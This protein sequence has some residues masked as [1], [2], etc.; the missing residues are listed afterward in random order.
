[1]RVFCSQTKF[2][3]PNQADLMVEVQPDWNNNAAGRRLAAETYAELLAARGEGA[4]RSAVWC[5]ASGDS[6]ATEYAVERRPMEG[7]TVYVASR[8]WGAGRQ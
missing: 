7:A 6:S 3:R 4:D 2:D 1:M 8:V 5:W